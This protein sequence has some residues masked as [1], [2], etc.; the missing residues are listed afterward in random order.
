MAML[1]HVRRAC[2]VRHC[3]IAAP[4]HRL[5]RLP[6]AYA[7]NVAWWPQHIHSACSLS[8]ARGRLCMHSVWHIAAGVAET[9]A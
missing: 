9:F 1:A 2:M 5:A 7:C 4:G 3:S 6:C 8:M